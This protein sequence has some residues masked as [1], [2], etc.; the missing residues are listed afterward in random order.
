MTSV[1]VT[2]A[3]THN[4][5]NYDPSATQDSGN[6]LFGGCTIA[7]ACNFDPNANSD[8]ESCEYTSCAGCIN[9]LGC[10]YDP[11]ALLTG[12][13]TFADTGYDCNGTCLLDPIS[14][15]FVI[16][17]K[18]LDVQTILL[19]ISTHWLLMM[20]ELVSLLLMGVLI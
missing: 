18:Y 11:T 12:D 2:D 3:W 10:N 15:E 4:A 13:C 8:D 14:M 7:I 17:L 19:K 5:D 9:P 20:M 1:L 16:L 6:C